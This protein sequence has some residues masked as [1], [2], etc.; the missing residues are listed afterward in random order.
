MTER[1]S[2][3]VRDLTKKSVATEKAEQVKGGAKL[4]Y[5]YR[6]RRRSEADKI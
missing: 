1:K 6:P 3:K 2:R 5:R 4:G